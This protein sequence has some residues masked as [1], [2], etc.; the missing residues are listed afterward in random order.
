MSSSKELKEARRVSMPPN[1]GSLRISAGSLPIP[2]PP[3]V[4]LEQIQ[5]IQ[6]Q[7]AIN[8]IPEAPS[9]SK[10]FDLTTFDWDILIP[11]TAMKLLLFPT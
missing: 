7:E 6:S 4:P 2:I 3:K 1:F 5:Q 11:A 8:A 10:W 9:S